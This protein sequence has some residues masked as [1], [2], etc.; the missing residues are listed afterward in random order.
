MYTYLNYA[1]LI[2]ELS[3]EGYFVIIIYHIVESTHLC[4]IHAMKQF[5]ICWICCVL[6]KVHCC[7]LIKFRMKRLQRRYENGKKKTWMN[8]FHRIPK[9]VVEKDGLRNIH[10]VIFRRTKTQTHKHD[11][12]VYTVWRND[13]LDISPFRVGADDCSC[14]WCCAAAAD[15]D[16][17]AVDNVTWLLCASVSRPLSMNRLF[18]S[19]TMLPLLL[20]LLPLVAPGIL[21][22][23]VLLSGE[24][25][26]IWHHMRTKKKKTRT[27]EWKDT[28]AHTH[29]LFAYTSYELHN[30]LCV[31]FYYFFVQCHH[32]SLLERFYNII[33]TNKT[34][35]L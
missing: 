35:A 33:C 32:N 17:D 20:L 22:V 24:L 4:N 11:L 31:Y 29:T 28:H 21:S 25:A 26:T 30:V 13:S 6:V 5:L 23:F 7:F 9:K 10:W 15:D 27:N 34:G 14:C 1:Y 18:C 12:R 16:A 3:K 19:F 8:D 2:L